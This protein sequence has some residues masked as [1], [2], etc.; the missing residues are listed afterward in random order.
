[1][2]KRYNYHFVNY[3][4]ND[5]LDTIL[6][7]QHLTYRINERTIVILPDNKPQVYKQ[8]YRTVTGTV[9][10]A[11]TN[12]PLPGVNIQLAGELTGT[13]TDLNGKYSIEITEGKPV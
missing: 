13:V 9:T 5:I 7:D 3:T 1:M 12:E 6:T 11:E 2:N 4:I 10:D 8:S